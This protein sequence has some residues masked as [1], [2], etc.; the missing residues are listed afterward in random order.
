MDSDTAIQID[1]FITNYIFIFREPLDFARS[2]YL[3]C[4]QNEYIDS[5]ITFNV[6]VKTLINGKTLCFGDILER[7]VNLVGHK[8]ILVYDYNKINETWLKQFA[9]K[10][11]I[12]IANNISS[13]RINLSIKTTENLTITDQQQEILNYQTSKLDSIIKEIFPASL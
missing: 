2:Y 6:F 10:L 5:N 1:P 13:D 7:W 9:E 12:N 3:Y 11:G 4:K 8:K